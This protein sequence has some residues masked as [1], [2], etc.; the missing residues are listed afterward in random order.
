MKCLK[1][2]DALSGGGWEV[3]IAPT[4][5]PTVGEARQPRHPAVRVLTVLT[6]GALTSCRTGLSGA[7]PDNYCSVSGAF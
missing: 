1:N 5:K 3:F 7:A 6:V 4:T 2:L